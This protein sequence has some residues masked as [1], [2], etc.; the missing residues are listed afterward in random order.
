[1]TEWDIGAATVVVTGGTTGIG[2]A[3]VAAL[4]AR[5]AR[6]IFTA[7][8]ATDGDDVCT[9]VRR[10]TPGARI[11]HREVHLDDLASVRA[12]GAELRQDLDELHVLINNA[13]VSLTKR[14]V[15]TDGFEMM[16]GVNHLG[17]FLLV[18][19]LRDLLVASAP[20]RIVIVASDAHKMGG[21]LDFDDLQSEQRRF[22]TVGGLRVY[23]RSKLANLLHT[24]ELAR[25]LDGT[26]VTVNA[27]HPGFVRTR[28]ARDTEASWL[29]E[30]LVWP[31]VG[32]FAR[33][34][35]QGAATSVHLASSPE[36][37]AVSGG[38]FVDEQPAKANANATD[39]EAA[40]RLW[41]ISSSLV[42]ISAENDEG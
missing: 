6:V 7:R 29:G 23:G 13:G 38:Y 12:F 21:A 4:A 19:E 42:G 41:R 24:R 39:D 8:S 14:R 18:E 16:F 32:R 15:T 33:S 28:L 17:H 40:A 35:E 20:S 2:R 37:E 25:R 27:L 3:T 30:R 10:E 22:G 26:G 5:G 1:M 34:P 9:A 11:E 31:L 36:L